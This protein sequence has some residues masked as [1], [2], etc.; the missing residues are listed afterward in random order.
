MMTRLA[1]LTL[2]AAALV[3][4]AGLVSAQQA[5]AAPARLDD[6]ADAVRRVEARGGT[7]TRDKTGNVVEV[8]LERTSATDADVARLAAI[9]TLRRLDL[10]FTYVTD[11]GIK[12][13]A[14][15][16]Q[17][18]EL[19]LDTAEFLTDASMAHLEANKGSLRKLV[20]RGVD[21]TDAGMPYVARL[22]NLRSLDISYT[23]LGD[24]GLEHLPEL[25]QLEELK[26]GGTLITGLNLNFLK[27]LPKLR[28]LSFN[29]IQRRNA[30]ACW[31]PNITDLDLDT[32]AMLSGLEDLDLGIGVNLGMGGK[33]AAPG[34]GN[35]KVTG[36]LR[37]T[38]LGLAKIAK[39]K[40]LRRLNVNGARLTPEGLKVL[41]TLPHLERLNVWNCA[42]LDD[43]AARVLSG[44]PTLA[45]LDMSYTPVGDTGLR[46]LS[47]LKNLRNL[48]LTE[49]QV[50]P[51]GVQAFKKTRPATF[52][53]WAR[54]PAPRGAPLTAEKPV[55]EE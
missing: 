22:T 31:T 9:K 52:V 48:Y 8:T 1:F 7:A 4:G 5:P 10:S 51:E 25:S 11:R 39:L 36:G 33:P 18:E 49:T 37:V 14:A 43:E 47:S 21:I 16:P 12:E 17:L 6:V 38:D 27:L 55:T 32:V 2:M 40:N 53:S 42:G 46:H 24:V 15:L 28:A 45:I 50:T 13:L 26:L 20:L 3:N 35:C 23:M 41:Q 34:G 19:T 44:V 29:G 54:R 30:G